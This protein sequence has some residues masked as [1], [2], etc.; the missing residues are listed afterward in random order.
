M[1]HKPLDNSYS[2]E[3]PIPDGLL[4]QSWY[5]ISL[6]YKLSLLAFV[7]SAVKLVQSSRT[8]IPLTHLSIQM[9]KTLKSFKISIYWHLTGKV[10]ISRRVFC[11]QSPHRMSPLIYSYGKFHADAFVKVKPLIICLRPRTWYT[12]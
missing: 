1:D 11:M 6:L 8:C 4:R 9:Y 10:L 3:R 5:F 12:F 7:S 2:D